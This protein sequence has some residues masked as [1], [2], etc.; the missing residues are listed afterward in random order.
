V[1]ANTIRTLRKTG[2]DTCIWNPLIGHRNLTLRL[3]NIIKHSD[4]YKSEKKAIV[5]L[6]FITQL[7]FR[8][9]N[10]VIFSLPLLFFYKLQ[11]DA[12]FLSR[13]LQ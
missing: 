11:R 5:I 6:N 3:T 7:F 9:M 8:H 10:N 1:V 13:G 2:E 12:K 4:K